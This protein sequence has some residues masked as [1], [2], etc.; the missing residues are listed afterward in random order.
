MNARGG[1]SGW[2][3]LT[4]SGLPRLNPGVRDV[5]GGASI[6]A[7]IAFA[8]LLRY[9]DFGYRRCGFHR[10]S[11]IAVRGGSKLSVECLIH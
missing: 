5:L 1:R 11:V 3:E 2:L 8:V 10:C 7:S 6:E 4:P 9:G